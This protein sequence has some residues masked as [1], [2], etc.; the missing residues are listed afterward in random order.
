[1]SI[2]S[3]RPVTAEQIH[4][5]LVALG[6]EPM[7]DPEVRP[8]GPQEEDRLHLLGSLLAKTELEITAATRLTEEEEIE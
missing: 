6:A 4:A 3:E 1:M 8:E 7:A 5:A 2:S